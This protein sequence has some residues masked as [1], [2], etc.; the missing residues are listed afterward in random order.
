MSHRT[1]YKSLCRAL[2]YEFKAP[3]YL[4]QALTHRSAASRNNERLE[5]LGDALLSYVIAE[6]LYQRF[7]EASEGQLTRLRASL[8]KKETLAEIARQLKL[9][10]YLILG[11]GEL[12]SGGW[13][14]ASILADAMEALLG[15][16][17]L[18]SEIAEC[19]RVLLALWEERLSQLTLKAVSKDPK[20]LLQEYLQ[21][22]KFGLPDYQVVSIT[23]DAH[24]QVFIVECSLPG[25]SINVSGSGKSRRHAEQAAA[26]SALQQI[27][28][29]GEKS[30]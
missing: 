21:G 14:R 30:V 8:V 20:T 25:M 16:I 13:R 3:D 1:D 7:P 22:R 4:A 26:Q 2:Q 9:G 27:N 23:G 24:D 19:R 10:D 6:T 17:Y 29:N 18:D 11:G 12:K 28:C 15:A 5:F